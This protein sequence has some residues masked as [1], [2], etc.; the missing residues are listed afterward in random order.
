MKIWI[1]TDNWKW[2]HQRP[3]ITVTCTE[4]VRHG[5]TASKEDRNIL[6]FLAECKISLGQQWKKAASMLM[7]SPEGCELV[8]YFLSILTRMP[9]ELQAVLWKWFLQKKDSKDANGSRMAARF[10]TMPSK[11]KLKVL[12]TRSVWKKAVG[13]WSA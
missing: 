4:W 7:W 8:V 1:S 13:G 9:Q 3:K 11:G 6:D 5:L 2:L 12:G 10:Q